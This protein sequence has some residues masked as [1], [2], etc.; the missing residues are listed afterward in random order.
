MLLVVDDPTRSV[1][2][3]PISEQTPSELVVS[4][5]TQWESISIR[6]G[7]RELTDREWN[8]FMR[9]HGAAMLLRDGEP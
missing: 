1:R 4:F 7:G 2:R 9:G 6:A 3:Q 8:E 5:D